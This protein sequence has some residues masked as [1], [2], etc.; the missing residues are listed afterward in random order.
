MSDLQNTV[1]DVIR[2]TGDVI[3]FIGFSQEQIKLQGSW[4]D[5]QSKLKQ[6]DEA[7][8]TSKNPTS[9]VVASTYYEIR[10][11]PKPTPGTGGEG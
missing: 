10:G 6:L 4:D 7:T 5:L 2:L 3:E 11:R 8:F 9:N 1:M